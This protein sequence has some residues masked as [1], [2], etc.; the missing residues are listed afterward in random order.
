M[1]QIIRRGSCDL[2][3]E[4]HD[5]NGKCNKGTREPVDEQ[6]RPDAGWKFSMPTALKPANEAEGRILELA[7]QLSALQMDTKVW[8]AGLLGKIAFLD[9]VCADLERAPKCMAAC[10][11]VRELGDCL[12]QKTR[13]VDQ[14][15]SLRSLR[16]G[17]KSTRNRSAG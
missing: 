9:E 16:G 2:A 4:E 13:P 6:D 7:G 3:Q 10:G 8:W 11:Q 17:W 15:A 1:L 5:R 14:F 12:E